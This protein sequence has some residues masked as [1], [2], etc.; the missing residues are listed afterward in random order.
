[1]AHTLCLY[2]LF[3][4]FFLYFLA[5]SSSRYARSLSSQLVF[6][7]RPMAMN[8]MNCEKQ[9]TDE[10]LATWYLLQIDVNIKR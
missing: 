1:M 7:S 8:A 10:E 9:G 4:H 5:H 3:L 2:F 6:I